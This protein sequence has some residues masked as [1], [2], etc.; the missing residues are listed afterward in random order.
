VLH[1]SRNY[2][3]FTGTDRHLSIRKWVVIARATKTSSVSRGCATRIRLYL[4]ELDVIVVH[5]ATIRDQCRRTGRTF[6]GLIVPFHVGSG[7][8]RDFSST[9]AA[10]E[11]RMLDIGA[12][13]DRRPNVC[14][15]RQTIWDH[16]GCDAPGH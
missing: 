10:S 13:P 5:S 3:H 1:F 8:S 16:R 4:H 11:R 2:E 6:G 12:V 7:V 9:R 15:P 14:V